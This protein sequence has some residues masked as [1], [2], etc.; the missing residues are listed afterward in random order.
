MTKLPPPLARALD[1]TAHA[2]ALAAFVA[3]NLVLIF[4]VHA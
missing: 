4:M 2:L 1:V 3:L